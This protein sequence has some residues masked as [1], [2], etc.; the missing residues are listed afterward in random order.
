MTK[1]IAEFVNK[2]DKCKLNKPRRKTRQEITVT[3]TPQKPFDVV[4][5]DTVGPIPKIDSGNTYAITVM[6]DS[7]KYFL[8]IP[9][10]NRVLRFMNPTCDCTERD[11]FYF[12]P[13]GYM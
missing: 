11:R 10:K 5:S 8:K 6:C 13:R 2:C 12:E 3:K 4:I 1:D 9:V 7:T